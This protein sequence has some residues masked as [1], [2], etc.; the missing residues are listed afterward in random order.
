MYVHL[1]FT[2]VQLWVAIEEGPFTP[3]KIVD[4][5]SIRKSPKE[6]NKGEIRKASY[7][8]KARNIFISLL[9]VN[10]EK[11]IHHSS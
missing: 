6:W 7:D 11:D 5:L 1:M 10:C 9:I 2:D 4:G 3:Q 8:L